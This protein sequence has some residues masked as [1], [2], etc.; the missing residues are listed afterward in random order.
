MSHLDFPPELGSNS[1]F[2]P[3]PAETGGACQLTGYA[4]V[5]TVKKWGVPKHPWGTMFSWLLKKIKGC[6][7]YDVDNNEL[8]QLL[9]TSA[10]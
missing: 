2:N 8:M 6:N 1:I 3:Q 7:N 10:S 4:K 9:N 5:N